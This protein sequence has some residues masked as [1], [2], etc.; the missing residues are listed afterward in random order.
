MV[1][2]DDPAI[3]EEITVRS[4]LAECTSISLIDN[5]IGPG[6]SRSTDRPDDHRIIS[7][8]EVIGRVL[9]VLGIACNTP[10]HGILPQHHLTDIEL[11]PLEI[12]MRRKSAGRRPNPFR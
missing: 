12:A 4:Q 11:L 6:V 2:D 8:P 10:L 9:N 5:D 3:P 7:D 1:Y